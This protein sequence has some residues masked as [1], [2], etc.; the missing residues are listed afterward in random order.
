MEVHYE[1]Q[2][3]DA[4]TL[5]GGVRIVQPLPHAAGQGG[6]IHELGLVVDL[7][8]MCIRDSPC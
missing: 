6:G 5:T 1:A 8:Q 7:H 2:F 4:P 3:M